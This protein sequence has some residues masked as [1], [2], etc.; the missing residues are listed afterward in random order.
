MNVKFLNVTQ[1]VILF[2]KKILDCLS[3]SIIIS[4]RFPIPWSVI[5]LLVMVILWI[6]YVPGFINIISPFFELMISF[7]KSDDASPRL[8][9]ILTFKEDVCFSLI[10]VSFVSEV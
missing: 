7:S 1:V 5:V 10:G 4:F 6:L 8:S 2:I 9:L 3:P